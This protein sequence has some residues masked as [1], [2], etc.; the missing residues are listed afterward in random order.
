MCELSRP[1]SPS[2]STHL[3]RDL[4][5]HTHTLL[6][7][8]H[9]PQTHILLDLCCCWRIII[10][11]TH[12]ILHARRH[13]RLL[14]ARVATFRVC[15]WLVNLSQ[16]NRQRC[17]ISLYISV[18]FSLHARAAECFRKYVRYI[19]YVCALLTQ[20]SGKH[21]RKYTIQQ[22]KQQHQKQQPR[23]VFSPEHPRQ[24]KHRAAR[25]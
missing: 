10:Q 16:H 5:K 17:L 4:F 21:Q 20:C 22:Q 14:I 8:I 18:S 15:I 6:A 9:P 2:S 11:F 1:A 25:Q 19:A 24:H 13:S 23:T 3:C 12:T 7:F